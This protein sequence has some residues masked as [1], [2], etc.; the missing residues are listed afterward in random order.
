MN[1]LEI[2]NFIAKEKSKGV[3]EFNPEQEQIL[4]YYPEYLDHRLGR[5]YCNDLNPPK[6]VI[7]MNKDGRYIYLYKKEEP[8][9]Y[10]RYDLAKKAFERVN[11]YKTRDNKI[12]PVKVE[13]LRSWFYRYKIVT[14]NPVFARIFL[15]N[16][17]NWRLSCYKNPVRYIEAFATS[18]A[19]AIEEWYNA[20]IVLEEV[21]R[22]FKNACEDNHADPSYTPSKISVRPSDFD[23]QLLKIIKD[24]KVVS[25]DALE[26]FRSF[27]L[28]TLIKYNK[29]YQLSKLPEYED[30]FKFNL[31]WE[32]GI[33]MFNFTN[34]HSRRVR[35]E[36]LRVIDE[37]NLDPE[38]LC[39]FIL[40][41]NRVEGCYI[42]DLTDGSHY[43]DY[44]LMEKTLHNENF[45]KV[46][47]YPKNWL[48]SFRRTKRNYNEIKKQVDEAK[49]KKE[50]SQHEDLVYS[51]KKFSIILPDKPDD[52]R[53]EGAL[54]KHCVA[55][56]VGR[57]TDGTTLIVFC[58]EKKALDEPYVTVEVRQGKVTQA[59]AYQDTKPSDECLKFLAQWA[60]KK[61]LKLVWNW[62][63]DFTNRGE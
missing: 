8:N 29:L 22:L 19:I 24:I 25:I 16:K 12:T 43:R 2:M 33:S 58:R 10:F 15:Y 17:G 39:R 45:S 42:D 28:P 60:D 31:S 35:N 7:H 57:V 37:F 55:S 50:V 49:F 54:L 56:Y 11:I 26:A 36:I 52:I 6:G 34:Y 59:Y 4:I 53:A 14:P 3:S 5:V 21:E 1:E 47:K 32:H 18:S 46:D 13:N 62:K 48:T 27:E 44:L 38:A 63:L 51:G 20:G 61:D 41:L 40:R 30:C 23:K 9:K